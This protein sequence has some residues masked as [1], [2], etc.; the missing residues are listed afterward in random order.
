M[1]P[2]FSVALLLCACSVGPDKSTTDNGDT[3]TTDSD[4]AV[5]Q[6]TDQPTSC[7]APA[8]SNGSILYGT[9][10]DA[11]NRALRPSDARVQFC[12]DICYTAQCRGPGV[13]GFATLAAG[14]GAFEVK[15]LAEGTDL[16][17]V[18]LPLNLIDGAARPFAV[19]VPHLSPRVTIPGRDAAKLELAPGLFLTV[20][21][22]DVI[23]P[24]LEAEATSLSAVDALEQNPQIDGLEGT[25][26]AVF[27]LDPFNHTAKDL[28]ASSSETPY[29]IGTDFGFP[30]ELTDTW[31]LGDGNGELWIGEY[32]PPAD[33]H[34][35][36]DLVA[37]DT[38]G[39]L[40]TTNH[41][42]K[43]STLVVL[44]KPVE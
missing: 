12:R 1:K 11:E 34:K 35:V 40:T 19:K 28:P 41:L 15:P 9:V 14:G 21:P 8:P 3:D 37:S 38:E 44:R 10:A 6:D 23:A 31:S 27:Y 30:V 42:P 4:S 16:A 5:T 13:W 29:P 36:G 22:G 32:G 24:A 39:R 25:V 26:L 18:F 17:T 43:L 33:W 7:D 20:G 2:Y